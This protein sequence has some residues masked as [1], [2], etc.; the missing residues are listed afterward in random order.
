[1]I[2]S[3]IYN[4]INYFQRN[5]IEKNL[6]LGKLTDFEVDLIKKAMPELI[7]NIQKGEE[8]VANS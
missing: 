3:K 6:G 2:F 7:A 8:F 5:G 4:N 1:M